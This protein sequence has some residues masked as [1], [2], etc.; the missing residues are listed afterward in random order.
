MSIPTFKNREN[1]LVKL[2]DGRKVWLSRGCS[3]SIPVSAID[4]EGQIYSLVSIRGH[5]AAKFRGYLNLICGYLDYDE[6]IEEAA[7]REL[8]EES[9]LNYEDIEKTDIIFDLKD[10]WLIMSKP[11]NGEQTV[12]FRFGLFFKVKDQEALPE[13]SNKYCAYGEVKKSYWEK[14]EEVLNVKDSFEEDN[15]DIKK[16]LIWGFNHFDLYREWFKKLESY[17]F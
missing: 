11:N 9:G 13:L 10:P 8:F 6:T 14:H 4:E 15:L 16:E 17:K 2:E 3:V 12:N 5:R 1:E 7:K